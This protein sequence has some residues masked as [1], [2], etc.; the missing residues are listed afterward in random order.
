MG[1][2]PIKR[3]EI[4]INLKCLVFFILG[5]IIWQKGRVTRAKAIKIN[6]QHELLSD[7]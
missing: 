7:M 1:S 2:D 5:D 3:L 4:L 6:R